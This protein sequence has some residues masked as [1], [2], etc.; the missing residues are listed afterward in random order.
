MPLRPCVVAATVFSAVSLVGG[1]VEL[2]SAGVQPTCEH[3][4]NGDFNGLASSITFRGPW[5][6][7]NTIMVHSGEPIQIPLGGSPPSST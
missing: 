2:A 5:M 3:M 1:A 7:G 4:N 6:A